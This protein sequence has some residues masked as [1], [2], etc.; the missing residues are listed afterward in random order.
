MSY[1]TNIYVGQKAI[2]AKTDLHHIQKGWDNMNA[3]K[4]YI[5]ITGKINIET[6]IYFTHEAFDIRRATNFD[7]RMS[8]KASKYICLNIC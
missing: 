3:S 8:K 4:E 6:L 2:A 7:V 1:F 5:P